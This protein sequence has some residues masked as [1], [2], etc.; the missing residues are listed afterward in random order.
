M[1]IVRS[2]LAAVLAGITCACAYTAP[3]VRLDVAP[4][5]LETLT[6]EWTGEYASGRLGRSGCVF[7]TLK[8]G[9]DHAHGDVLMIPECSNRPF[10]RQPEGPGRG[11]R[12]PQPLSEVLTIRFVRASGKTITGTLDPYWDPDRRCQ[13]LTTFTGWLTDG[14]VEGTFTSTCQDSVDSIAGRWS[15]TRKR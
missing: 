1:R 4:A 6:G 10:A 8:G 11:E 12:P 15:A 3:L 2:S 13:A 5:D 14:R 7:F 9:E